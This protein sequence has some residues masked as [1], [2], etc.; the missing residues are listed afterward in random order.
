MKRLAE[1]L[2]E[3]AKQTHKF[4]LSFKDIK[5]GLQFFSE[6][7]EGNGEQTPPEGEQT[8]PGG[9]QTSPKGKT[10]TEAEFQ[11]ALNRVS[12]KIRKDE[13]RKARAAAEQEFGDKNKTEM[14]TL[15]DEMRTI[16]AERDQEKQ[17]AHALKMKDV[18]IEKLTAAGFSAG[19]AANVKGDTEEEIQANIEAFKAN[20]ETEVTKRVKGG[21]AGKTPDESK[22]AQQTTVDPVKAAFDKEFA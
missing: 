18:A 6:D 9:K 20:M 16:K 19:F 21:L 1:A 12:G 7:G 10:Y 22:G 8:P 2:V 5:N 17:K 4:A 13:S 11:E 15:M 14:E 3:P